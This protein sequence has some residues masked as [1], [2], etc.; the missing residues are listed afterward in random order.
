MVLVAPVDVVGDRDGTRAGV[1]HGEQAVR[2]FVRERAEQHGVH[3]AEDGCVRA[4]SQGERD[5]GDGRKT[6]SAQQRAG[7]VAEILREH[8]TQTSHGSIRLGR[9]AKV[10]TFTLDLGA[11]KWTSTE[12][13]SEA[14]REDSAK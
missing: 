13:V 1:H 4:D 5:H 2:V 3:G 10:S 6:G 11:R 14:L 9:S 7:S 8:V 12:R